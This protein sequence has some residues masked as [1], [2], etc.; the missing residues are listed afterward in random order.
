MHMYIYT[1]SP[2]LWAKQKQSN[3]KPILYA[4]VY[5]LGIEIL[6]GMGEIFHFRY[7]ALWKYI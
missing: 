2:P 5:P 3:K 4:L 7:Y 6:I 1:L